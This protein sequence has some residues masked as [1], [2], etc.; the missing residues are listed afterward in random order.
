MKACQVPGILYFMMERIFIKIACSG[1]LRS[2]VWRPI[3]TFP[4]ATHA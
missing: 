2:I 3:G 1:T 4:N